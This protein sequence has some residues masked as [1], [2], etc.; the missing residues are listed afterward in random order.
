MHRW[1]RALL[2]S[3]VPRHFGGVGFSWSFWAE[4]HQWVQHMNWKVAQW[5]SVLFQKSRLFYLYPPFSDVKKSCGWMGTFKSGIS[6][7]I[8]DIITCSFSGFCSIHLWTL[9]SVWNLR[10]FQPRCQPVREP[11][12]GSSWAPTKRE[13]QPASKNERW[14]VTKASIPASNAQKGDK[15]LAVHYRFFGKSQVR[16]DTWMKH[17]KCH[18]SW[19]MDDG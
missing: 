14:W 2:S 3:W 4:T 16:W 10:A 13:W 12:P 19:R 8:I 15:M 9:K 5:K 1:I 18:E 17:C 7:K 11:A 6:A